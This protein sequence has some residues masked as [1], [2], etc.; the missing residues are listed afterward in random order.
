[1][2]PA[3][4]SEYGTYIGCGGALQNYLGILE[5]PVVLRFS[6]SVCFTL[7]TIRVFEHVFP[8]FLIGADIM[9][10]SSPCSTS[11]GFPDC[12]FRGING[13]YDDKGKLTAV[14]YF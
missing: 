10:M 1:M 8:L 6:Q 7:P 11:A 4:G 13:E 12:T 5:G 2:K 9:K 3:T 14:M